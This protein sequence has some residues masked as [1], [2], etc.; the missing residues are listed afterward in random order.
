M[1][2][3]FQKC[4][5]V[6]GRADFNVTV[7]SGDDVGG[8][9]QDLTVQVDDRSVAGEHLDSE[10]LIAEVATIDDFHEVAIIP[11]GPGR[12]IQRGSLLNA[13]DGSG[14]K[15]SLS[16]RL[17]SRAVVSEWAEVAFKTLIEPGLPK[18]G[19]RKSG[20][21]LLVGAIKGASESP[22]G[23]VGSKE[24]LSLGG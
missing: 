1:E 6:A 21:D 15:G 24:D 20:V 22:A 2:R 14:E 9:H 4:C 23:G 11:G 10:V 18:I 17:K 12:Q 7:E 3:E 5:S 16:I 8:E 13:R 19:V